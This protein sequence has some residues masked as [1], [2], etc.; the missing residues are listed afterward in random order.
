MQV[1]NCK[2]TNAEKLLSQ[3]EK[4]C[5]IAILRVKLKYMTFFLSHE[6]KCY[7]QCRSKCKATDAEKVLS[8]WEKVA[9]AILR[10]KLKYIKDVSFSWN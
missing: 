10:V 5:L 2:A 8:Q 7:L 4:G 3:G 1:S 9:N 6:I